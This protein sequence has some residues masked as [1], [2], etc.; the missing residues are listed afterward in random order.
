MTA[1]VFEAL[2]REA[3]DHQE[4]LEDVI[5]DTG[6]M[7]YEGY[8]ELT[9]EPAT[10]D[11]ADSGKRK[12]ELESLAYRQLV[13][14]MG[15]PSVRWLENRDKCPGD[16]E[17]TVI[18]RLIEHQAARNRDHVL[19]RLRGKDWE[20]PTVRAVLSSD[21]EPLDNLELLE[22][23]GAALDNIPN[24]DVVVMRGYVGDWMRAYVLD[25]GHTFNLPGGDDGGGLHP[26]IYI[27]NNEVGLGAVRI[28]G[29]VWRDV[30]T[31]GMIYGWNAEWNRALVHR[32]LNAQSYR[33]VVMNNVAEGFRMS[34]EAA[35]KLVA[36]V[37]IPLATKKLENLFAGWATDGV[38]LKSREAWET[39]TKLSAAQYG[40]GTDYTMFDALQGLTQAA[41]LTENPDE[42]EEMERLAGD[43]LA[44]AIPNE[45][46]NEQ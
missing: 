21:Y 39:S 41:Q 22:M 13:E 18:D 40:R 43:L 9:W 46:I 3:Q 19:L 1:K 42:T 2:L 10:L 4:N 35:E 7:G 27:S 25:R 28:T 15:G 45:Q 36:T 14:R 38:T 6:A 8:H 37:E 24:S 32:Y 11:Q 23:V 20:V 29:G 16:L 30:C 12:A 34:K 26:G 33:V 31:N 17:T 5:A 44:A